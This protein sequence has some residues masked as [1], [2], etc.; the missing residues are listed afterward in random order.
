[1]PVSRAKQP[2]QGAR[3]GACHPGERFQPARIGRIGQQ[4]L[5]NALQPGIATRRHRDRACRGVADLVQR[6]RHDVLHRSC[7]VPHHRLLARRQDQLAQEGRHGDDRH[8]ARTGACRILAQEQRPHRQTRRHARHM[9]RPCRHPQAGAW[10]HDE[11]RRVRHDT[12]HACDGVQQLRARM[13]MPAGVVRVRV[14]IRI[15]DE[16]SWRLLERAQAGAVG[17]VS[18]LR[19]KLAV[20]RKADSLPCVQVQRQSPRVAV[21][22]NTR[23]IAFINAAHG[24]THY[25]LLILPTAVLAMAVPGRA[26]R[27]RVWADPGARHGHVPA[28]RAVLAAAGVDCAT[29]RPAGVDDPVLPRH[30]LLHGG[31]RVRRFAG[32][33]GGHARGHRV[34]RGDLPSDR[35][36]HAG[37]RRRRQ[38]WPR[39][40]RERRVRQPGCGVGTGGDRV[41]R[42]HGRLAQRLPAA[43]PRLRRRSVSHGC[44][45]RLP[46][47][48]CGMERGRFPTSR[49]IWCAAR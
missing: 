26:V 43:G 44:D 11:Q 46:R 20:R 15:A 21:T 12:Q 31:D 29:R 5:G 9:R 48:S 7:L 17:R 47:P 34:V 2:R 10:R 36:R 28:L 35:H 23:L 49:A 4:R 1:M 18:D 27:R 19:Q 25:S 40:R 41:A 33:A 38:A 37:R 30:R 45:C 14:V 6:Q 3:R 32:G 16:G 13:L 22:P 8:R 39:H 24:F 42:Q